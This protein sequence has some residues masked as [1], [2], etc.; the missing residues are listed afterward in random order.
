MSYGNSRAITVAIAVGSLALGLSL[1]HA[2]GTRGDHERI[3]QLRRD[4]DRHVV[5]QARVDDMQ[6]AGLQG[7]Y[8]GLDERLD[9]LERRERADRASRSRRPTAAP[10]ATAQAA[11][12]ASSSDAV[13]VANCESGDLP[14]WPDSDGSRYVG[15]PALHDQPVYTGK[16]QI[17]PDEWRDWGGRRFASAPWRATEPEQDE[18]AYVGYR[19]RGWQPWVCARKLSIR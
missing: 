11:R 6:D 9:A 15:D 5:E 14:H 19:A 8:D 2:Y 12:W 7:T 1:S 4:V 18:T 10:S 13:R 3:E 17:G 16:W